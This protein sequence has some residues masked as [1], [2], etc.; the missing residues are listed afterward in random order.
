MGKKTDITLT[1]MQ[2]LLHEL[3]D[4]HDEIHFEW[5]VTKMGQILEDVKKK[6]VVK[7]DEIKVWLLF[8][9]VMKI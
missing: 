4:K 8:L 6:P 5:W 3:I 7:D 1:A 9:V 2:K